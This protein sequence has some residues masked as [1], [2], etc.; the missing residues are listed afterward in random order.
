MDDNFTPDL[1]TQPSQVTTPDGITVEIRWD[2]EW[3][4]PETLDS[5][6]VERGHCAFLPGRPGL[7]DPFAEPTIGEQWRY[8][9]DGRPTSIDGIAESDM[10]AAVEL[11]IDVARARRTWAALR[12]QRADRTVKVLEMRGA[13]RRDA[14]AAGAPGT[15]PWQAYQTATMQLDS[16][17][18]SALRDQLLT[19]QE[20]ADAA[21]LDLHEVEAR[22]GEADFSTRAPQYVG[23]DGF[24]RRLGISVD[25]LRSYKSRGKLPPPDIELGAA[26][27]WLAETVEA[28]AKTRLGRGA[29]TD[30]TSGA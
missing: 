9:W 19:V 24:A 3:Y 11:L 25:T 28:Y 8:T 13:A 26:D 18:I 1:T 16:V 27:G 15:A 7:E 29:R 14:S 12:K 21:G 17:V 10:A 2:A 22:R 5:W 23:D 4:R 6:H 30:L 20:I